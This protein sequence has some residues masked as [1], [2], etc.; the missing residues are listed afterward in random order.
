MAPVY[1]SSSEKALAETMSIIIMNV[2]LA[3]P[4]KHLEIVFRFMPR[5]QNL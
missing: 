2:I 3:A 5:K 4:S 1:A